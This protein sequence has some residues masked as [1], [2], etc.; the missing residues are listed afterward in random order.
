MAQQAHQEAA[1]QHT[2][3]AAKH[4]EA[5]EKHGKKDT[6]AA[7]KASEDAH[8][9]STAATA[10]QLRLTR[11]RRARSNHNKGPLETAALYAAIALL[12]V[13]CYR[14]LKDLHA[15]AQP[16]RRVFALNVGTRT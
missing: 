3:A 7:Q 10:N 5:A 11:S 4:T 16:K 2:A 15:R 6:A 14:N 8:T 1:K 9:H 13:L 12:D